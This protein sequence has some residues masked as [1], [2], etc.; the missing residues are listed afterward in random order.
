L[1]A[2]KELFDV[3]KKL[4]IQL[5]LKCYRLCS[6]MLYFSKDR[7]YEIHNDADYE[8]ERQ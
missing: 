3:K 7:R 8:N 6:E 5:K 1:K 2:V 4:R